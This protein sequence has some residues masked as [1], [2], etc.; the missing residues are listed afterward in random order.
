MGSYSW[1]DLDRDGFAERSGWVAPDDG[2]LAYDRNGDGRINDI[3]ELLGGAAAGGFAALRALDTNSDN[4][5]DANDSQ[6]ASLSVWRDLNSDG[7]TDMGELQS[8]AAAGVAAISLAATA[9]SG[10]TAAGNPVTAQSSYTR[11]DGSSG[12]IFD[13][14]FQNDQMLTRYAYGNER[15]YTAEVTALPSLAGYGKVKPLSD[16]LTEDAA[17]RADLKAALLAGGSR[18]FGQ[19]YG[20][21]E[22]L[23]LR[24][25]GAANAVAGSRGSIDA[26]KLVFLEQLHGVAFL[27]GGNPQGLQIAPLLDYYQRIMDDL[28]GKVLAQA[29]RALF[30]FGAGPE[31]W[32]GNPLLSL[33]AT[34][35]DPN[36]D[37]LSIDVGGAVD[38]IAE[39]MRYLGATG[40]QRLKALG[41]L[42]GVIEL[43]ELSMTA[44]PTAVTVATTL[45]DAGFSRFEISFATGALVNDHSL[46]T[47]G[48]DTVVLTGKE[49]HMVA[50]LA[51]NDTVPAPAPPKAISTATATASIRSSSRTTA[52]PARSIG[53]S[54]VPGSA[55]PTW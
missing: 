23:L 40:D 12:A 41:N 2:L 22:G 52:R 1:F 53:S 20:D 5:I 13:L 16:A 42:F 6:F 28:V 34:F 47:A 54:S 8:L 33:S 7:L 51:G 17:L 4:R 24:W 37:R 39:Q 45:T 49:A 18:S 9:L 25:A 15:S 55:P 31:A 27:N 29:P 32:T 46:G 14:W 35:Y 3:G 10:V 44:M 43:A 26:R 21:I 11:A 19:L 38:I 36:T 30:A 48:A 50:M